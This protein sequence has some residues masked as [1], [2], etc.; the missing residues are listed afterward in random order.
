M[1]SRNLRTIMFIIV[2]VLILGVFLKVLPYI[3][4]GSV[5][6]YLAVKAYNYIKLKLGKTAETKSSNFDY[7]YNSNDNIESQSFD[8]DFDTSN[9]IEVEYKDVE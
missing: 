1:N 5:A 3:I 9:A 8:S 6:V 2:G 4:L 7:N